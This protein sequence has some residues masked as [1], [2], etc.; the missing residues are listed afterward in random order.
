MTSRYTGKPCAKEHK[1]RECSKPI[2]CTELGEYKH[3]KHD[4]IHYSCHY[5]RYFRGNEKATEYRHKWRLEKVY[6]ITPEEYARMLAAQEGRCFF[7][8]KPRRKLLAVD[9]D[10]VT[11]RVRGLLCTPCNTSLGWYERYKDKVD[12]YV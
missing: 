5:S 9:H 2:T 8:R 7:C 3:V 11:G 4:Y 10:H 1:C 12:L 6:G